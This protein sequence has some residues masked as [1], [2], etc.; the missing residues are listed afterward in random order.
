MY[1]SLSGDV[2]FICLC[3]RQLS[4]SLSVLK[5]PSHFHI[6]FHSQLPKFCLNIC[7]SDRLLQLEL[8]HSSIKLYICIIL[9]LY[10]SNRDLLQHSYDEF[11]TVEEIRS[12]A[13]D[14]LALMDRPDLAV[15][16][17]KIYV[18]TLVQFTKVVFLDADILVRHYLSDE[19]RII[20]LS[21]VY[22]CYI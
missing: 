17:T 19:L 3:I 8:T 16:Y 22:Y 5:S 9:S 13:E 1:H 2:F 18:W 7:C 10:A 11:H 12:A 21:Y 4:L 15:A 14:K 20:K 6:I